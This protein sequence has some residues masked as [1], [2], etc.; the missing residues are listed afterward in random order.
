MIPPEIAREHVLVPK[1]KSCEG[2]RLR[3]TGCNAVWHYFLLMEG[4]IDAET[5]FSTVVECRAL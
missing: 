2:G 5:I 4:L 1:S 3:L